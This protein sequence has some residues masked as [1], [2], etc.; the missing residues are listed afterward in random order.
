M[1]HVTTNPDLVSTPS[2]VKSTCKYPVDE[3]Y[4]LDGLRVPDCLRMRS[5]ESHVAVSQRSIDT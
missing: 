4:T 1:D 2:E 3:L 5:D